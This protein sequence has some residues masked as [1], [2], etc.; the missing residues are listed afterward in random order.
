MVQLADQEH[1]ALLSAVSRGDRP[2]FETL[3]ASVSPRLYAVAL[4]LLKRPG[5]A[6]EVLQDAFITVWNKAESYDGISSSPLTWLTNIVRNRA[7][8]WLRVADNRC[9]EL[10]EIMLN[11]L[12][13]ADPNPLEQ[14][15]QSDSNHRLDD[16]LG[17]LSAEQRQ[18]IVLA[19]YHGLSHDEISKQ[20]K[21]PLG[22]TKSWI[23][24][25]LKQLKGCLGL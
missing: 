24:R 14:L 18:S 5:W 6:E 10:D 25:G 1:R 4:R 3:Y 13:S 16:C 7:I 21:H 8:D 2:A 15:E 23:R 22:T 12:P 11:E 20:L 9:V 17:L 19:Y